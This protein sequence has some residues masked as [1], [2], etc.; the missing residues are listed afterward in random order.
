MSAATSADILGRLGGTSTDIS[1]RLRR[2]A[3]PIQPAGVLGD[4][5]QPACGCSNSAERGHLGTSWCLST[6]CV[7]C[8]PGF[9]LREP[10]VSGSNEE[11]SG[12][13]ERS[14]RAG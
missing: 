13:V 5:F 14:P 11:R 12:S 9:G 7:E 10:V 4:H 6:E 2:R 8:M 3:G 1:G